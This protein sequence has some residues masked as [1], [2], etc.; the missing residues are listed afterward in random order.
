[1][2]AEFFDGKRYNKQELA[3]LNHLFRDHRQNKVKTIDPALFDLNL[4]VTGD[5]KQQ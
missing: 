1:M 5:V 4:S 3:R 2:K